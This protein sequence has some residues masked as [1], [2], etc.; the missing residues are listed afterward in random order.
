MEIQSFF[1]YRLL[2]SIFQD[3]FFIT[4]IS[5]L[6]ISTDINI[7]L[8]AFIYFNQMTINHTS[9]TKEMHLQKYDG[10]FGKFK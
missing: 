6:F 8:Q 2:R 7:I 4:L 1:L 3:M 10:I 5:E 9:D